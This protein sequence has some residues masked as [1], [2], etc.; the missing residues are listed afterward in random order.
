MSRVLTHIPSRLQLQIQSFVRQARA[1]G[2]EKDFVSLLQGNQVPAPTVKKLDNL[3]KKVLSAS[4]AQTT[5][6]HDGAWSEFKFDSLTNQNIVE[7]EIPRETRQQLKEQALKEAQ[8]DNRRAKEIYRNKFN[9]L[10]ESLVARVAQVSTQPTI[11]PIKVERVP[12]KDLDEIDER[13]RRASAAEKLEIQSEGLENPLIDN[14]TKDLIRAVHRERSKR[15]DVA[16][17]KYD[18]EK[19]TIPENQEAVQKFKQFNTLNTKFFSLATSPEQVPLEQNPLY[20]VIRG[21]FDKI[22]LYKQQNFHSIQQRLLNIH[23]SNVRYEEEFKN[24]WEETTEDYYVR[25]PELYEE[26]QERVKRSDYAAYI[27]PPQD[28]E[29]Q[30]H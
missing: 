23:E 19:M 24:L 5:T 27:L 12:D 25:F 8:N 21:R 2:V 4:S 7:F 3:I 28:K 14:G 20:R 15:V 18:Y 6:K 1:A 29:Q 26:Y 11:P 16:L 30:H 13:L 9:S 17:P 22:A 10:R